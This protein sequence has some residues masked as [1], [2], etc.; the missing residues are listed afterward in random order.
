[1]MRAYSSY[2]ILAKRSSMPPITSWV[3]RYASISSIVDASALL[4]AT[5]GLGF[6]VI[7]RGSDTG[8]AMQGFIDQFF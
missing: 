5:E 6:R 4:G 1:M 3:A 2:S 8:M 7:C